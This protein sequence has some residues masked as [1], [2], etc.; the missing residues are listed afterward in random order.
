[1][2]QQEA[3][4]RGAGSLCTATAMSP[5]T[6]ALTGPDLADPLVQLRLL[7]VYPEAAV[8]A[9]EGQTMGSLPGLRVPQSIYQITQRPAETG[10]Q[11]SQH[12]PRREGW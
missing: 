8:V 5:A 11:E 9:L 10:S 1:M 7:P 3:V 6:A 4:P 12:S 2:G